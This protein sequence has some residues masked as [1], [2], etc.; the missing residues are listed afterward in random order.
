MAAACLPAAGPRSRPPLRLRE[1]FGAMLFLLLW[2]P[3]TR[4]VLV[5]TPSMILPQHGAGGDVTPMSTPCRTPCRGTTLLGR[6][7]QR[8]AKKHVLTENKATARQTTSG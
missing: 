6:K 4:K 3:G 7:E 8:L 1:P 2:L 5:L